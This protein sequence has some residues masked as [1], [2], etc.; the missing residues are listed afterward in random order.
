[1]CFF[2]LNEKKNIQELQYMKT[3]K[4]K[5]LRTA[6]S[7]SLYTLMVLS[8]SHVNRRDP[9]LS[10]FAAKIPA[11]ESIDP[12]CTV[13]CMRWK[14]YPERQSQKNSEPL[15]PKSGLLFILL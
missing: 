11:S 3:K 6:V 5:R 14:L 15:S 4:Q 7:S 10:N 9:D 2:R 8:A 12:G 1:M 13:V